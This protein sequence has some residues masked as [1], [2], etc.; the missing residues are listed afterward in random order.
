M[1]ESAPT[2]MIDVL[3]PK[4]K[5]RPPAVN[6]INVEGFFGPQIDMIATK[7]ARLLFDRCI[8]AGMLD[9]VDPDRPNPGLKIPYQ[10][11]NTVTTQMFWDSDFGKSIETAAYA[12][13]RKR[14]EEL[15][16]RIDEVVDAYARLQADD[17]YLNSFFLRI[18]PGSRWANLRDQHELYN[19]GHL[20]EGAVAYYQATGKR[21]LLDIMCRYADLI[22]R[23][24]GPKADQKHGYPGHPELELALV[25]LGRA[26]GEQRY[27][28]LAKY[29]VDAR[30]QQPH[31][32][33]AE[34]VARGGSPG[35]FHFGNYEYCQAHKPVRDQREVV[36][37]AV[38][39][40][41]L[42]AGMADVATEF[43]DDSL[44]PALEALWSHLTDRNLYVT[45]GFGP[46]KDNEGLTF[47][48]DLPNETAYAETCASVAL[49]F[50]A[51][52]ML[53]RAPDARF[54]DV[55]E[56][57]LYNG[58]LAGLS[59]DGTHFFYDNPLESYGD[60]HRW[61]WHRCPCCP[62]N[63]SR[64]IASIGTY[65]YGVAEDE[66]ALHLY[67]QNT[68]EF[69]IAGA[70]I[71]V[72]QETVYPKDGRITVTLT[73]ETPVEFTLSLRVPGWAKGFSLAVNGEASDAKP[74]NGY[75]RLQ[76]R[77]TAGDRV[78]LD[79][80]MEPE[81]LYAHQ[82]VAP[83]QG[84][85]ALLRG[86][87]VYCVEETD[88]KAPLN[89]YVLKDDARMR[90]DHAEGLGDAVA[91]EIEAIFESQPTDALYVTTPPE[92]KSVSLKAIP[93]YLWD[94]RAP[95]AMLVWLR[96]EA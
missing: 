95:G 82:K 36:G 18:E 22:D 10:H 73:P 90:L 87:L 80:Q 60:H 54:A 50:W 9:Q 6:Q 21:K 41:Y 38:R 15:E 23:T 77:W 47:D 45:G 65:F 30:G 93:Y 26:T 13:N 53:G 27:L 69:E 1:N 3:A 67:C 42:Y 70:R 19:A 14:D 43:S 89:A 31:Y 79:L 91:L 78:E 12:L 52:R 62:P 24:F 96:R 40:A 71:G 92:R 48:Y 59:A 74:E 64:L 25:R 33:D 32:F 29:F 37:H 83:D 17:G 51:S 66:L 88:N 75:L 84:R 2:Q 35:D 34:A 72:A 81:M 56:R 39:A 8:E 68:A 57:A 55:M 4:S 94:N 16:A 85:V 11:G 7:T 44:D 20:F 5:F 63:I 76:R 49:V 46:S 86:P 61:R 28:D 58:A